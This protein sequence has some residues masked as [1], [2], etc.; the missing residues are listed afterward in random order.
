MPGRAG[1]ERAL[2]TGAR[3]RGGAFGRGAARRRGDA[4]SRA[5]AETMVRGQGAAR[6]RVGCR[7]RVGG[8]GGERMVSGR[9]VSVDP[10]SRRAERGRAGSRAADCRHVARLAVRSVGNT[11]AF[12][13]AGR[14]G[15]YSNW[16]IRLR[17]GVELGLLRFRPRARLV[18]G[19][20]VPAAGGWTVLLDRWRSG[21]RRRLRGRGVA[22]SL[23]GL[24]H[25]PRRTW[26]RVPLR[27][28]AVLG[29]VEHHVQRDFQGIGRRSR[30]YSDR[31]LRF[32]RNAA[33]GIASTKHPATHSSETRRSSTGL[34]SLK[35]TVPAAATMRPML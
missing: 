30:A 25:R 3:V 33:K 6:V 12:G 8:F 34:T 11:G 31:S 26:S 10:R 18:I 14:L 32:G 13:L 7:A 1:H 28:G 2:G 21:G 27:S 20:M 35:R 23:R 19:G 15:S 17:G 4:F 29:G 16:R 5:V 22:R 24:A 9:L